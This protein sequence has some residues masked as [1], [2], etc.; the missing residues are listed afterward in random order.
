LK[1]LGFIIHTNILIAFA[2]T[3]LTLATQV[4]LG[5]EPRAHIYLAL[6]F[7]A[8]LLDYNLHRFLT[9]YYKHEAVKNEKLKWATEHLYIFIVLIILSFGGLI[10]VLFLVRSEILY[11]LIPLALL[12]FLYSFPLPGKQKRNFRLLKIPGMKTFLIALVWTGATVLIPVFFENQSFANLQITLLLAERFTFI[13]A[14]AIPFDIRDLEEDTLS[15]LKTLPVMLGESNSMKISNIFMLLSLS[16]ATF[17]YV[18]AKML[19]VLP[20]YLFSIVST[21]IFINYKP[22]KNAAFYHHGILDGSILLH[23]LLIFSSFYL[24][25]W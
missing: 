14:I 24:A 10:V 25:L 15:S 19:F 18:D 1:A 12:S 3:A 16:I 11:L 20:A 6:I 8:T 17:H 9:I 4:Q 22:L 13:F 7:L 21:L 2:A 5:M 23:G